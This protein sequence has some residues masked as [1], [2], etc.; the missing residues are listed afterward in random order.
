[1]TE[2]NERRGTPP[3]YD[4]S[5]VEG[6]PAF[7]IPPAPAELVARTEAAGWPGGL[8]DRVL[9]LRRDRSEIDVWLETGFPTPAMLELWAAT[10]ATLLDSPLVTRQATWE[11][12]H[13]L[14]DLCADSPQTV[15]D[16]T[17]TVERGPNPYAQFRLQ[18]HP[19]VTLLEDRRVPL[20]MTAS[21]V[22]NTYIGGE[23]TSVHYMSGWRVRD[24]FRGMGL[25]RLLQH[26]AGPGVSWFGL[27]TYY[28]V[29]QGNASASWISQVVAEIA[30]RP[31][32][33]GMETD[34]LTATVWYLGRPELGVRSARVRPA[35][36]DDLGRCRELINRTHDGL[37][38]FRPYSEEY[39]DQRMSDPSWGA[40][41]FFYPAVYGLPD[42]RVLEVDG[43]IVACGGLWDRGRDV[44]EVWRHTVDG[45]P[46]VVV[47]PAA[48]MDF[49][50]ATGREAEMAELVS[51]LLAESADLGRSGLLAALE[52]LPAVVEAVGELEPTTE[53]RQLNVNPFSSPGL[54]VAAEVTRPYIDLAYW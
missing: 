49:G 12:G 44:R 4:P 35:E 27:V 36:P 50:F 16:W 1:M 53:T 3:T 11:D 21:S 38:L 46:P 29:R 32:G 39:L 15:G 17:V 41:P 14:V 7:A 10:Q 18:E 5:V 42:Y 8:L 13:L 28:F 20:G 19:S 48:M 51:H 47:D 30:D 52:Q 43:E 40:K 23:P 9:A 37:D 24:G 54:T 45:R 34:E 26:A 22:R 25:S 33:Y 2:T 31:E 6:H